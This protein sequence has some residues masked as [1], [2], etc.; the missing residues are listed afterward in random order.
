MKT[1]SP[2]I[3]YKNLAESENLEF[4][5]LRKNPCDLDL[6]SYKLRDEYLCNSVIPWKKTQNGI[7]LATT[8]INKQIKAWV[9]EHYGD[10]CSFAITTPLDINHSVN[11]AFAN[12][13]TIEARDSLWQIQPE[14]SAKTPIKKRDIYMFC[15]I[16]FALISGAAIFPL[17]ALITTLIFTTAFYTATMLFKIILMISGYFAASKAQKNSIMIDSH[18]ENLPIY[19]I[20]IP[21]YKEAGTLPKLV[22]AILALDYPHSKLDVKL[23][24]ENDDELT[25]NAIKSLGAP[26]IFEMIQVPFS[27]PRTKP[28]AC[29]YALKFARG[30]YVT[31]Y[32]AEDEPEPEQLKKVLYQFQVG[33]ENLACVQ[34]RLNYFNRNEN[35]LTRMF[36]LEYSTLFDFTLFGLEWIGIP[37]LLGGT[38]NHFR[39]RILRKLY[40]WDPYN[41]TEDADLGI[42][43]SKENMSCKM[44]WSLTKEEAPISLWPWIKQR[45]R[46]IKG[47]MQTWLVH[48]RHPIK[49]YQQIG[50]LGFF[51]MQLFLG[52]P[53][54][55]F[56]I[57]PIMWIV[58]GLFISGIFQLD[59]APPDLYSKV[60]SFSVLL[61][62]AGIAMQI[63]FAICAI[64]KNKWRRMLAYSLVFPFYW[65]LHCLASFRALWQLVKCPHYW[66]KTTHGVTKFGLTKF[67]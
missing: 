7:I 63:T 14:Y 37:I 10:G 28:K 49:L 51:G 32:D 17:F 27:L 13:N 56:I 58:W 54:L 2:Y 21:L 48:M 55:I 8:S 35:L 57:S 19:T 42:R 53:T 22:A 46:W 30:E 5:D 52:A 38:S 50:F 26:Y 4:A 31:I 23:I 64:V 59:A 62:Y 65:L 44:V 11:T 18:D 67:K 39:T 40:A 16:I 1:T 36:A 45:T 6:L 20:L 41:V 3:F 61:L 34:A 15:G 9:M 66:E 24:V 60:L 25:I 12:E 43:I 29:N 47:H 33:P